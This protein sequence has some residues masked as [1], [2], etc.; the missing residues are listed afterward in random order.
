MHIQAPPLSQDEQR[1]RN[2]ALRVAKKELKKLGK[3]G[4]AEIK[5]MEEEEMVRM[6]KSFR[7]TGSADR[8]VFSGGASRN[9]VV[10]RGR[11]DWSATSEMKSSI[12]NMK[13]QDHV[14]RLAPSPNS[15]FQ[16]KQPVYICSVSSTVRSLAQC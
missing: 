7:S 3:A 16:M 15:P 13:R 11:R 14:L 12:P 9:T 10:L 1:E 5:R 2:K 8:M 6:R 4:K